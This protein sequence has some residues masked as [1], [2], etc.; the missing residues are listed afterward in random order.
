MKGI[1]FYYTDNEIVDL[2][3]YQQTIMLDGQKI[4]Y[5]FYST[6]KLVITFVELEEDNTGQMK[7]NKITH[8]FDEGKNT[9]YML[10]KAEYDTK[11]GFI[12][13][14]LFT[15][16]DEALSY[17]INHFDKISTLFNKGNKLFKID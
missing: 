12:S 11:L 2:G 14:V 16:H 7:K 4:G 13:F 3:K 8:S 10:P 17:A 15:N 5:R 6:E 9:I 1:D